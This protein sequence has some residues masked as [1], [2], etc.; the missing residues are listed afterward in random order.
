MLKAKPGKEVII[1]VTNDVGTLDAIAKTVSDK[2]A[3]LLATCAWVEGDRAVIHLVT[4]DHRRVF[5]A[6]AAQYDDVRQADV[7]ITMAAHKPG[8]L[9]RATD[10]LAAAGIDIHHFYATATLSQEECLFV[11]S[12]ANNDR[13]VVMLNGH[14]VPAHQ[15]PARA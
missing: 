7:V 12:T 5:D 13:A 8:M 4:D 2:G 10:R 14:G 3:N 11:L 9:R 6:L 15:A 1:R